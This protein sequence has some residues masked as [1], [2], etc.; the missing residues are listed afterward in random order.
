MK[1]IPK[2]GTRVRVEWIDIVGVINDALSKAVP[3]ACWSE[4][5]LVR[6][7]PEFLVLASS[8]FINDGSDPAGDY[9]A[10]VRGCITSIKRRK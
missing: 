7:E 1:P 6:V 4:G 8:Q 3:Q 10:I 9:T 5:V 2:I